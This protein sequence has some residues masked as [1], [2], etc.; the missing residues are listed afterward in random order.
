MINDDSIN[1]AATARGIIDNTYYWK[2]EDRLIAM[3]LADCQYHNSYCVVFREDNLRK[4]AWWAGITRADLYQK[5]REG[6]YPYRPVFCGPYKDIKD[7]EIKVIIAIKRDKPIKG[8]CDMFYA[9]ELDNSGEFLD[10][11]Q[12]RTAPF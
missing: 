1:L 5:L 4:L 12:L 8:G 7:E 9:L 3:Y 6:V 10:E 2:P 11:F